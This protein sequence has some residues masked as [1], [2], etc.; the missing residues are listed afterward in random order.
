M[1]GRQGKKR[2]ATEDL[3]PVLGRVR[4]TLKSN[5]EPSMTVHLTTEQEQRIQAI[6]H[7]GAYKTVQDV[8]DAAIAAVEQRAVRGFDG[9]EAELEGLLPGGMDS[10]ELPEDEFWNSVDPA[11]D[12]ALA[13]TRRQDAVRRMLEFG[14]KYRSASASRSH[15]SWSMKAIASDGIVRP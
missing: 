2:P 7:S 10:T 9:T 4:L 12:V 14:D 13:E 3:A 1:P 11:T 6:I 15:A 8:V 5:K